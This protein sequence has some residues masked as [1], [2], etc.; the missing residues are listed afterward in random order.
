M[1]C[2]PASGRTL[3]GRPVVVSYVVGLPNY[4][5][6]RGREGRSPGQLFAPSPWLL[7]APSVSRTGIRMDG[8]LPLISIYL[9]TAYDGSSNFFPGVH[10]GAR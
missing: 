10:D 5:N 6:R 2:A 1:R 3:R 7:C 8:N 9:L 4:Q